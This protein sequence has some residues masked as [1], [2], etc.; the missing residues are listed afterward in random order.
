MLD[1]ETIHKIFT[2]PELIRVLNIDEGR[3][4]EMKGKETTLKETS[5]KGICSIVVKMAIGRGT[6][7]PTWS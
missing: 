5:S 4:A 3:M 7:K 1:Y 2:M 6:A